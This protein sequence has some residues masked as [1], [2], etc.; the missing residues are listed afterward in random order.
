MKHR[1][2]FIGIATYLGVGLGVRIE[3]RSISILLPLVVLEF[4]REWR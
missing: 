4:T 3:K 2:K 1:I